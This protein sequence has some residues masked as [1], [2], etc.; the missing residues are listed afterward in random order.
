MELNR[1][2]RLGLITKSKT[3]AS[4]AMILRSSEDWVPARGRELRDGREKMA[5]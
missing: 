3:L 4:D 5:D 2:K 1:I